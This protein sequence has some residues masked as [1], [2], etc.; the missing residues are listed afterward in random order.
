VTTVR[1]DGRTHD[2]MLLNPVTEAAMDTASYNDEA[3]WE[4]SR[5]I[6]LLGRVSWASKLEGLVD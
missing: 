6:A 5:T 2:F 3:F 4:P 1:R